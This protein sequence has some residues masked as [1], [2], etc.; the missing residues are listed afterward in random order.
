MRVIRMLDLVQT[1]KATVSLP[2]KDTVPRLAGEMNK[3]HPV[4]GFRVDLSV[5]DPSQ[6]VTYLCDAVGKTPAAMGA[7]K[8]FYGSW[9]N[10]FFMPRPCML[11][12][13]GT[14]DYY[15]DPDDYSK[16]TD[17]TASDVADS[18]YDGNAMMEWP[19]IWY[20]FASDA[21]GSAGYFYCSD[22]QIDD[23]YKCWCNRDAG[24]N[25]IPHFYT[26][27]YNGSGTS[28]LRSLSG[29]R[30]IPDNGSGNLTAAQDV[31]NAAA[32]GS[33]WY[34]ETLADRLL[35]NALLI[36]M[37]KTL[38]T[39]AAFGI[40]IAAEDADETV[41]NKSNYYTGSADD[42][43]LFWGDVSGHYSPVKVFGME[44]WWGC[45]FRRMA[46]LL[47]K[48]GSFYVKLTGGTADGSTVNGYSFS[49]VSGYIR[50]TASTPS[51]PG[52]IKKMSFSQYGFFPSEVGGSNNTYW[53]DWLALWSTNDVFCTLSAGQS[54]ARLG[55]FENDFTQPNST[56]VGITSNLS[57]KPPIA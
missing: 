17:G 30:L 46:G 9:K 49:D 16:K 11:R 39:K 1:I 29:V 28:K 38:N 4:Y 18:S 33:G 12:S 7:S 14:V 36:L 21:S 24:N 54:L 45:A 3:L 37:S 56:S 8:F 32:N 41:S 20:K 51:A 13:D 47:Y 22:R 44:N 50:L 2:V 52:Y 43:G 53:C 55:A 34:V 42:K 40:G 23:S 19:L 31:S 35:I 48:S 26:A 15:L 6:A 57:C 5:S 25:I 27:I 10:A